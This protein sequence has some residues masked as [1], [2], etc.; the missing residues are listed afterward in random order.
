M[1]KKN[2]IIEMLEWARILAQSDKNFR[3][4]LADEIL[5]SLKDFS[6]HGEGHFDKSAGAELFN[7]FSSSD[8]QIVGF[9]PNV[10]YIKADG[11]SEDLHA[12]FVHPWAAGTLLLKH[13]TLPFVV[14]TNPG[15]R[16]G[17]SYL[18][19]MPENSDVAQDVEGLTS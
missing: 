13:K 15:I 6:E 19:E 3:K 18:K 9:A 7:E 17:K 4:K 8:Y 12:L 1:A 11:T 16:W 5:K 14:M 2:Q 10:S